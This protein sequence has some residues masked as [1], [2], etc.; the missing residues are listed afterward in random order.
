MG[1]RKWD[2]TGEVHSG[3]ADV[4]RYQKKKK[5][6]EKKKTQKTR[7]NCKPR[8]GSLVSGVH[9]GRNELCSLFADI[10]N[11]RGADP[12]P[13]WMFATPRRDVGRFVGVEKPSR[14]FL[15][16][17]KWLISRKW[18]EKGKKKKS[19]RCSVSDRESSEQSK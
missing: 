16:P 14:F 6:K 15:V 5:K 1:R 12:S 19:S 13:C 8:F 10:H 11:T 2:K 9:R 7:F 3:M 18:G 17:L 4:H